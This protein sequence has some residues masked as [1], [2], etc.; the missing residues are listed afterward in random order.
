[1]KE[2]II[3]NVRIVLILFIA[4]QG[5]FEYDTIAEFNVDSK[6]EYSALSSTRSQKKKLK[7]T[8]QCPTDT[9]Q[10]KIREGSPEGISDYGGKDL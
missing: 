6:A 2:N 4:L 9:V 3:T 8:T 1:M 7:Q 5:D 10:V